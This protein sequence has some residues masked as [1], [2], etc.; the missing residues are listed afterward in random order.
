M[1]GNFPDHDYMESPEDVG[2][3]DEVC[4]KVFEFRHADGSSNRTQ[5]GHTRKEH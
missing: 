3:P 4:Y 5:C 1:I 2:D